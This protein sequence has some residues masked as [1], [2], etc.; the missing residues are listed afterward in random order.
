MNRKT[1]IQ[2]LK[3]YLLQ[4]KYSSNIKSLKL[5][6]SYARDEQKEKNDLDLL[7][8]VKEENFSLLDLIDMENEISDFLKIKVDLLTP[9]SLSPYFK[10]EVLKTA[11]NII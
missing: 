11:I 5:F 10:N 7:L 6:G 8:E 9:N 3:K 1:L 4:S 2:K